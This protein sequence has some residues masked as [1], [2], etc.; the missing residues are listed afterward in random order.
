M[1]ESPGCCIVYPGTQINQNSD[2]G[3]SRMFCRIE[4]PLPVYQHGD[5]L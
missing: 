3:V 2:S 4:P 1:R 5:T